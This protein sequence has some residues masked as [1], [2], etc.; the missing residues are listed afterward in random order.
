MYSFHAYVFILE[1]IIFT[2]FVV[3]TGVGGGGGV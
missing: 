1:H 2:F 3:K